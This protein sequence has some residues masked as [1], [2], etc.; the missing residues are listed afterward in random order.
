MANTQ[1]TLR[2]PHTRTPLYAHTLTNQIVGRT[3]AWIDPDAPN[4]PQLASSSCA[5]LQQELSWA[6]FLGLQAVLLPAPRQLDACFNYAQ[7]I[8]QVRGNAGNEEWV[9]KT[10]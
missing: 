9:L 8:N 2:P 5:A 10:E 4:N 7:V 6:A 3:S 1:H